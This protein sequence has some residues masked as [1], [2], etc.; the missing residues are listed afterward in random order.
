MYGDAHSLHA[1][2]FGWQSLEARGHEDMSIHG[3]GKTM[4][5][6]YRGAEDTM[7]KYGAVVIGGGLG[8]YTCALRLAR[9]GIHTALVEK[10][11]LGGSW[12]NRGCIPIKTLLFTAALLSKAREGKMFGV[13]MDSAR[14]DYEALRSRSAE[15][16]GTIRAGWQKSLRQQKVDVIYGKGQLVDAGKVAVEARDGEALL[17]A[18][19]VI[20]CGG[21]VLAA[22]SILGSNLAGVYTSDTLLSDLPE[23]E[24]MV[25]IG[26]DRMGMEFTE[27]YHALGTE[28]TVLEPGTRV[29]P[30]MD[31]VFSRNLTARFRKAGVTLISRASVQEIVREHGKL[32]VHYSIDGAEK[33]VRTDGVLIASQKRVGRK[34]LSRI[35]LEESAGLL[36]TDENCQTSVPHVYAVGDITGSGPRLAHTAEA[37]GKIAAAAIAGKPCR[38]SLDLIPR[39]VY[40]HPEMASVGLTEEEAKKRKLKVNTSCVRLDSNAQSVISHEGGFIKLMA[41]KDGVLIGAALQ[42]EHASWLIG[43]A[44]LAMASGMKARDFA[45]VIRPYPSIEEALGEAAENLGY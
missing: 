44:V 31:G 26:G 33:M 1:C 5:D 28:V 42:C 35:P 43:E 21:S 27:L 11:R 37:Q 6:W 4:R 23:L 14:P 8:G 2:S 40:T 15:V 36:V 38:I 34:E 17:E 41:R 39:V 32:V 7:M 29:L 22:S 12:L 9:Y 16:I 19:N 24:R 18:E 30:S 13:R 3:G 10:D 25:I 45:A 20:L